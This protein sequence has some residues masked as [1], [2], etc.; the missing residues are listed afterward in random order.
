MSNETLASSERM[1]VP[2]VVITGEAVALEVRAAS[3]GLRILSGLIDYSLYAGGLVMSLLSWN[4][5]S[6]SPSSEAIALVLLS[7]A[8]LFW[9]LLLPLTIEVLSR[10]QS[11]GR[12]ITGTRVVRDDGGSIRFRHALVRTLLA[13]IEIWLAYGVLASLVCIVTRRGKRLGDLL[14]G[15]YVVHERSAIQTAPPVL[16]PPELAGWAS[17][18]DLRALPG[19]LALV[20]R[21]FLQ[22]GSAMRPAPRARL[23]VQLAAAV[24][25]YVAP[26]APEGTHPERFLAAVLAER[27]DREYMLELRDRRADHDEAEAGLY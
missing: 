12:L 17:Q 7:L 22:R 6:L 16:M 25:P 11:A 24:E 2:E 27:R 20:A 18:A 26:P 8:L 19:N 14:A 21:T 1:M 15:T 23:S 5:V 13:T 9:M 10:G 4:K 3:A